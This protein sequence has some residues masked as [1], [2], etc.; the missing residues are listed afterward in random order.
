MIDVDALEKLI[1]DQ[2]ILVSTVVIN[3]EVGVVEPIKAISS[4]LEKYPSIHYHVDAVQAVGK[5]PTEDWLTD[6]V[7][8]ASFSAH[9]F[10]GPRGVGM[11]YWK[12]AI[13]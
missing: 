3:S 12:K 9:K 5:I 11:L 4:I 8:F 6:R 1:T 7:D 2:T 10:H 13:N